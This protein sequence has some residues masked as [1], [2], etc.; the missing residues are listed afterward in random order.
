MN[1]PKFK[2]NLKTKL[3]PIDTVINIKGLDTFEIIVIVIII[4]ILLFV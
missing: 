2:L 4:L 3:K 1:L